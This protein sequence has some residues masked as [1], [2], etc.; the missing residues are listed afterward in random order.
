M[1][2]SSEEVKHLALLIRLG[3]SEDDVE[4]FR[5]QLSNILENFE[6]LQQVDTTNVAP[7]APSIALENVFRDDEA[8]PSLPVGRVLANAPNQEENHFKVRAVLEQ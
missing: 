6:I 5:E 1:K 2:L 3:L 4:R 7:T 8:T